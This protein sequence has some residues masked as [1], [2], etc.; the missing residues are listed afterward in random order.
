MSTLFSGA[1]QLIPS[2]VPASVSGHA[3][4]SVP[5][6]SPGEL[7]S[8]CDPPSRCQASRISGSLWLETGSY[9][10][11][12]RGCLPGAEFAPF[13]VWLVPDY[14]TASSGGWAG[15]QLAS[16]SLVLLSSL[17]CKRAGSALGWGFSQANSL[18]LSLSLAIPQF[19][20][21]FHVSS[22]ILPSGH[23]G[24]VLTLSNAAHSSPF[25][26]QLL[27]AN[28][29]IWGTFRLGVAFR[30]VICGLYLFIFPPS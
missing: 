9:F 11:F 2:L 27:V 7:I 19:R 8:G 4:A 20:L 29:S 30:R 23:S 14:P 3:R 22:L 25:S 13:W 5:C 16:S 26:P 6:V 24:P 18:S 28:V 15:P 10:Q 17:F 12:G 21:L 1:V